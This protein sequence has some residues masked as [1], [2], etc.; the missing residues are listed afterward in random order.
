MK[1][2]YIVLIVVVGALTLYLA[3]RA[4]FVHPR[5][6]VT[7]I[8]RGDLVTVVYATGNVSA[9]STATL[10]SESGGIVTYVGAQ[11]GK[12]VKRGQILLR[13]DDS[14]EQLK[15]EQANAD[16]ESARIDLKNKTQNLERTVELLKSNSVTQKALDDVQRDADLARINFQQSK[17]G[18]DIAKDE[19]SKTFVTAPF[20][21]VIISAKA[22]LGDY[23]LPN[24]DCFQMIA[25]TSIL[26]EAQVDEQ[27]F[28]R[29]KKG[30][31][32][33]VAFD[34][35]GDQRFEGYVYRIVPKTDEATKTSDVFIKLEDAPPRLNVGMTT[36]VNII[37]S[38]LHDVLLV[39]RTA[40][41]QV[42]D[43]SVVYAVDGGKVREVKVNLGAT[44]G[45]LS[46]ILGFDLKP[47]TMI[48]SQP[49]SELKD[50]MLVEV[51]E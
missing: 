35:Y 19:L 7:T 29:V 28:A 31:K 39:P 20:S 51:A 43:S 23:L 25:P 48:I 44:D 36:T 37:S 46:E 32:C 26:V 50:G 16:L 11:E 49:G 15:V 38:E 10:R 8:Q 9:D 1:R 27:D 12:D 4:L 13:T 45:K 30:Q 47:G 41:R 21:G 34:A 17:L 18:L 33:V 22:K 6:N 42:A 14:H 24:G 5:A 3:F 40:V 2:K